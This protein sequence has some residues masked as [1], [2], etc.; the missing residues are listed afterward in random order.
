MRNYG[1]AV[2]Q[3]LSIGSA[4]VADFTD[5]ALGWRRSINLNYGC[6]IGGFRLYPDLGYTLGDLRQMFYELPG[7]HLEERS[8]GIKTWAGMIYSIDF[9]YRGDIR[10]R[11]LEDMSNA[12][13]SLFID[14]A[15]AYQETAWYTDPA[16]IAWF[17]RKENALQMN[18]FPQATAQSK[19]QSVLKA[20]SKVYP[21]PVNIGTSLD[22]YLEVKVLGYAATANWRYVTAQDGLTG[23]ANVWI[24]N[25][26]GTDCEFISAG[27]IQTNTVQVLRTNNII[28]RALD[29]ML[30]VVDLGGPSFEPWQLYVDENR[31]LHYRPLDLAVKY[32][33]QE[34]QLII[35]NG[36][37]VNPW[38]VAPGVVR[39]VEYPV[40]KKE[41]GNSLLSDSRD[42]LI[43]EIDVASDGIIY[44]NNG[45]TDEVA[46]ISAQQEYEKMLAQ[47]DKNK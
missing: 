21:K 6:K 42:A 7:S 40:G 9:C 31:K 11:S 29:T 45:D 26:V 23:N 24:S 44:L 32:H 14:D 30:A 37:P 43:E 13:K 3:P 16:S 41:P 20:T 33:W 46:I 39:D 19:A 28:R 10:R 1:L 27:D 12:V 47:Q 35:P 15:N 34:Q 5:W 4:F 36:E 17:G 22:T 38:M 8:A 18:G 2:F 25:I